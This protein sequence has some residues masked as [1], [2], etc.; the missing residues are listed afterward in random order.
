MGSL[1][2]PIGSIFHYVFYEPVYN[3]L[4]LINGSV[5]NFALAVILVTLVLR[6]ALI[7]L[8]RKQLKSSREMQILQPKLKELQQRYRGEPQRLME[9]QRA[10]YKE[11]GVSPL[12]GCLPLLVQM[13]VLYALYGAFGTVLPGKIQSINKD[14]YPFL[15]HLQRAPDLQFLWM[16]LGQPDPWHVLPILAGALTFIQLR[17]AMPVRKKQRA[18]TPTDATTQ[19]TSMMQYIMPFM[20]VFIGW[21]FYSGL[22][23]YWT[24][25][26]A[27]SAAQQYFIN[28]RNWGT[29]F[30]GIPGMEHMVPAP[31]ETPALAL[32]TTRSAARALPGSAAAVPT[33]PTGGGWRAILGQLRE[34]ATQQTAMRETRE[35]P[36]GEKIVDAAPPESNGSD[37][38]NGTTPAKPAQER[39]GRPAKTGPMLVKPTPPTNGADATE[40]AIR[41]AAN[42]TETPE[43]AIAR[44]AAARDASA[45]QQRNGYANG[46][47]N[48]YANGNATRKPSSKNPPS[49]R[50]RGS[51]PKGGR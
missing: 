8:T 39:R 22:A 4:M 46:T 35:A 50:S 47:G 40:R 19:A 28:G 26:T 17:M 5:H 37:G 24:I 36:S 32:N 49:A 38:L 12:S 20:T 2:A 15:P 1:L 9:E 33:A 13:P 25:S 30:V 43:R 44:D 11:H 3:L 7:P 23:L 10:L 6:C 31:K 42:P 27:F 14:I 45:P 18:G 29:L 16:N 41:E 21:R 51:R 48:G 34:A